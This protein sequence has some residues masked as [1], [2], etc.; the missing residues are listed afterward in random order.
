MGKGRVTT[1][2]NPTCPTQGEKVDAMADHPESRRPPPWDF[3]L[4]EGRIENVYD[5][6]TPDADDMI[7]RCAVRLEPGRI[8][9]DPDL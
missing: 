1:S 3:Q 5:L 4:P 9:I 7:V 6:L 2:S 8:V